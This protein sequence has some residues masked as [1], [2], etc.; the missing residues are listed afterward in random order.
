MERRGR[1]E[2]SKRGRERER[3]RER[4]TEGSHR[5]GETRQSGGSEEKRR[6]TERK[7]EGNG[8]EEDAWCGQDRRANGGH[9]TEM[10][11]GSAFQYS[12]L[13]TLGHPTSSASHPALPFLFFSILGVS[14]F[15]SRSLPSPLSFSLVDLLYSRLS[16]AA[17]FPIALLL[18]LFAV[19]LIPLR[20]K[21]SILLWT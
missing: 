14:L 11:S 20:P 5:R 10:A 9:R 4:K 8:K 2:G 15:V 13:A 3:E 6:Q 12:T 18:L 16:R 1:R 19:I 7:R 17:P 21:L